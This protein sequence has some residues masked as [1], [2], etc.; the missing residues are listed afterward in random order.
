MNTQ[1]H[2][3]FI[4]DKIQQLQTAILYCHSNSVLKLPSSIVEVKHIDELGC[5]W[6]TMNRPLQYIHEFDRSFHTALNFYKK[7]TMFFLNTLGTARV[8]I[9]PE[10]INLL[11]EN[12]LA[13][14]KN[15]K[16]IICVR[17]LEANYYEKQP[18]TEQNFLQ[19]CKQVFTGMFAGSNDYYYYNAK[20]QQEHFA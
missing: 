2:A 1:N 12:L 5:V 6:I 7:G 9:D 11:P 18:K 14:Y 10:E 3:A 4:T 16:M 17:I 13:E 15:G 19:K 20:G 8:V